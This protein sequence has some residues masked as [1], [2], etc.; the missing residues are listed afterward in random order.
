LNPLRTLQ[1]AGIVVLGLGIG[2]AYFK[3]LSDGKAVVQHAFDDFKADVTAAQNLHA[4]EDERRAAVTQSYIKDREVAYAKDVTALSHS[5]SVERM[6]L[7][8]GAGSVAAGAQPALRFESVICDDTARD[9][10]VSD[11]VQKYRND[12][13]AAVAEYRQSVGGF[14]ESCDKQTAQLINLQEA[15]RQLEGVNK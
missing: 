4:A 13:G 5:W 14:L 10:R 3:G 7:K 2:S 8:A 9:K 6:R 11:I 12:L 1:L 15:V